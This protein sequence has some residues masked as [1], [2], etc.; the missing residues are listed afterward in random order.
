MGFLTDI[1]LFCAFCLVLCIIAIPIDKRETAKIKAKSDEELIREYDT[2][3]YKIAAEAYSGSKCRGIGSNAAINAVNNRI[4]GYRATATK[5]ANELE[6]RNYKVDRSRMD[7]QA[8]K[9][10]SG[11]AS[12][13]KRAVVGSIVAGAPGAVVGAIS[14]L[15]K[16]Q[17]SS[18]KK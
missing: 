13:V 15:D 2:L 14:A 16:N 6:K 7:G 9:S 10:Q 8:I 5:I 12:V 17:Q 1:L 3:T 18:N 11:R 4:A